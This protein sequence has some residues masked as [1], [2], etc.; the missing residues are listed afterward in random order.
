[1]GESSSQ[2]PSLTRTGY[3]RCDN[4]MSVI[5]IRNIDARGA[6]CAKCMA[7]ALPFLG[8]VSEGEFKGAL[9]E[10]R[11]GLRSRARDFE[12]LRFDPLGEEEREILKSLDNAAKGCKYQSGEEIT[13][14]LKTFAGNSGCSLS[15]LFHNIRSARGPGLELFEAEVRRWGI[16]WDIIGLAETW[17][18]TESEKLLSVKGF[19]AVCATRK[20]KSGGGVALLIKEGLIFRERADLGCFKEGIIESVFV[21]VIRGNNRKNEVIGTVYRPPGG[22]MTEFN[23]EVD[24]ILSQTRGMNAYIMGDFNVDILKS[25][26]HKPTDEYLEGF[27]SKGFYPLI[28]LPTRITDTS[29]TLIDNIWTNNLEARMASG[30]I[31]VRI[32]DHLPIFSFIGGNSFEGKSNQGMNQGRHRVVNEA[33]IQRFAEALNEWTFDEVRAQGVEANV[34]RFRNEFR[35]L[36]DTVFPWANNKKT[37]RDVEKPWLD[38]QEFKELVKE[39]DE[40]YRLKIRNGLNDDGISRLAEVSKLVNTMRR[41]LKRNYFQERLEN[42]KNDLKG[43]WEVLGEALRGKRSKLGGKPCGYFEINGTGIT[44]GKEIAERFCDF[45][46]KVGPELAKKI[47]HEKERSYKD[48]MGAPVEDS[49]FWRP[50]TPGEVEEICKALDGRKGMGW[51]A[52]SPRVIKAVARE[53]SGP[54]SRLFNCCMREGYYPESFKVARVVPVFKSEDPIQFSNYRPV[55]VLP[56]LSQVFERI[57]K[58]RLVQFFADQEVII[59]SQYGFRS[60]HSTAMAIL[61]MVE[62]IRGAWS[63][64]NSALGVFVDLKKAFDTVDHNILL[65]KLEH[66][67]IRGP[68][69]KILESYLKDRSQYVCYGGHESERGSVSCGVPQGSVLGPLFFL[70]YVNDMVSASKDL[71]LVLFADDTNIFAKSENP[72]ELIRK[73]NKGMNEIEK[74]FKCNRLTLNL[75]KTEYVFF[76]GPS[77]KEKAEQGLEIGGQVIRRVEGARFLGVWVDE[78]LRWAEHIGNVVAKIGRLTG[79]I[80]RVRTALGGRSVHMLYN[81]LVLPHLQYCLI[82][83]GDFLEGKN[84]K[85]GED[86]LKYQKRIIGMIEGAQGKYHADPGFCKLGILK[87]DDLYK[88]QIRVHAWNFSRNQLPKNQAAMLVKAK[89]AHKYGTR[90]SEKGL[91]SYSAFD[92]RSLGYRLPKEWQST[93]QEIRDTNSLQGMKKKSKQKFLSQYGLFSCN[94]KDCYICRNA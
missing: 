42:T 88:Q 36:Y 15:M 20:N 94:T 89:D 34:A 50:S 56:V 43:T 41:K 22:D 67:G 53:L 52:V 64:K 57:L 86:L 65:Q 85:L 12:G 23:K 10:F 51:D 32:S 37:K 31:T 82:V 29:A 13:S 78:K 60:G 44:E 18:D 54:L 91:L 66:Y 11:E 68:T 7:N 59:P 14:R 35:D 38:N 45:Y 4:C 69:L 58:S 17:L 25:S 16:S 30:L 83:W 90:A 55:S 84:K 28:S 80:G 93:P 92:E 46:C 87:I 9:K 81:A 27:Y 21:E 73:V 79:V 33:R 24:Q 76:E 77:K 2:N 62:K 39:K 19:T 74:W 3:P 8:I 5:R 75:K 61:D 71:E 26:M 72:S 47:G 6:I 1:M 49:L 48:Y 40:L 70:I 63:E